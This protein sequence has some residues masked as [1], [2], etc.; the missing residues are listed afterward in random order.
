MTTDKTKNSFLIGEDQDMVFP[1]E[2]S[3]PTSRTPSNDETPTG[4]SPSSTTLSP[5]TTPASS[6]TP[7]TPGSVSISVPF[8]TPSSFTPAL[9]KD[10]SSLITESPLRNE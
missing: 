10:S 3:T 6:F 1:M 2:G 4:Y 5:S 7:G 8:N 9:G